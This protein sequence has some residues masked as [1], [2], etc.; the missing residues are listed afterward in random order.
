MTVETT[1]AKILRLLGS[2]VIGVHD[3]ESCMWVDK[4]AGVLHGP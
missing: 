1:T 2:S 4:V 3:W